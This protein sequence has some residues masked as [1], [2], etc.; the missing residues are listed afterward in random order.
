MHTFPSPNR[1]SFRSVPRCDTTRSKGESIF[2]VLNVCGQITFQKGT[3]GQDGGIGMSTPPTTKRRTTNLNTKP[4]QNCQ[5][6]K[7]YGSP[8]TKE[9]KKK[10]SP[11]L[12]GGAETG[13]QV[14]RTHRKAA[15]GGAGFP[16][17]CVD[18]PGRTT[19]ERV[20]LCNP[21]FQQ[22][23]KASNL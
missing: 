9:L 12:A 2:M 14:E 13:S 5:K 17:P 15:A 6:I 23:N 18:K 21:G 7:L 8:T 3:S 19:G 4:D 10:H 20:R 1:C 16:H 11:R 22:G